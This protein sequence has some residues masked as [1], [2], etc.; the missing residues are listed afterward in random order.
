MSKI[1]PVTA[2]ELLVEEFLA[3][4]CA[5]QYRLTREIDVPA[6][7]ISEIVAGRRAITADTKLRSGRQLCSMTTT[8][9]AWTKAFN[10]K[11]IRR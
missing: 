4:K 6:R 3:P 7:R 8:G 11:Q 1:D 10:G 2:G 5:G 9:G